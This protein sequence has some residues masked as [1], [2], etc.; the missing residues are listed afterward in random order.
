MVAAK[1]IGADGVFFQL[2]VFLRPGRFAVVRLGPAPEQFL[3]QVS[4][5]IE[6]G[7]LVRTRRRGT[8]IIDTPKG[9]LVV[10]LD[11][12]NFTL[13]GGGAK[14]KESRRQAAVRELMEETGMKAVSLTALFEFM[15]G[16]HEG[17]RGG[18]FRNAHKVF[19][20]TA[21]GTP[22]P[23]HEVRG[24]AYYDGSRP[25]LTPSATQIILRYLFLKGRQPRGPA[26]SA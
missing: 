20:V 15:G 11:G 12:N 3:A 7:Q 23:R 26:K 24:I 25:S 2:N 8:A 6:G 14:D 1:S 19:L 4:R 18:S 10:S 13:P 21:T 5:G 9:I 16:I 17:P 22:E